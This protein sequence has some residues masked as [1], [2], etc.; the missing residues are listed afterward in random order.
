MTCISLEEL[1]LSSI[2][3]N[4]SSYFTSY[5]TNPIMTSQKRMPSRLKRA[6]S[7]VLL[8]DTAVSPES[9]EVSGVLSELDELKRCV[10]G[11][12]IGIDA[13][14][15]DISILE[16]LSNMA[17]G[18][19]DSD[20]AYS[21]PDSRYG[22]TGNLTSKTS[23]GS[24][25]SFRDAGIGGPISRGSSLRN[26]DIRGKRNSIEVKQET[27]QNPIEFVLE[28]FLNSN[29]TSKP[30]VPESRVED[31]QFTGPPISSIEPTI[32]FASTEEN[33]NDTVKAMMQYLTE[34]NQMCQE[35][36]VSEQIIFSD[37]NSVSASDS[38]P[39]VEELLQIPNEKSRSFKPDN[40]AK[41]QPTL[42]RP[43]HFHNQVANQQHVPILNP[44]LQSFE[45][46]SPVM[47]NGLI[48]PTNTFTSNR[49]MELSPLSDLHS[50]SQDE[51]MDT[52]MSHYHHT[53]HPNG[54]QCLVWAC[55]ACKRKTGPHDRRR[56]ATLRERRRLKRVN[57]AYDALK[58][59]ACAN[60]NQR[61]PKVEILRNAITY[62]Y[63]LQ[64]MLYGDQQSDAKS[65]ETK[66]ETTLS[67]G[68]TFVSKTEVDSPFYQ[69][70]DV[71]LT[72]SRTS[73]PVESLLESTSSSFIM[74]DL[75]D[76]NIQPQDTFPVNLLT[77]DV[78]RP[79]STTPDVIAVVNEPPTTT[80]ED[81]NSS[82]VTSVSNSDTKGA[83][84]LVCLTSIVERID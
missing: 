13:E 76:E 55:K 66:P 80:T 30:R 70:D 67:L 34:T 6:S 16:E 51:D 42:N 49:M 45:S 78:T 23:F 73:S 18:C 3:S 60:P 9:R 7:D 75:G 26:P 36:S 11:N 53:S 19:S 69:S 54:H 31:I 27:E 15:S 32:T 79:L 8:S 43:K 58:R 39:S 20:V 65:P 25:M 52:K 44:E 71:R 10:E 74:S 56:A 46:F 2:F 62:I 63:N 83:S 68:E 48:T 72:S 59:C 35:N 41:H 14:K 33:H 61:L 28:S 50:L 29:E 57:Q 1:D 21:S 37:L 40:T 84:S 38:L 17:S 12:Y 77:D 81:R 47:N 22:S 24:G 4:S 82:P 5:A 64:H